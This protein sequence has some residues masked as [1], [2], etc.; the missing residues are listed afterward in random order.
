MAYTITKPLSQIQ[1]NWS[2]HHNDSLTEIKSLYGQRAVAEKL[3][4]FTEFTLERVKAAAQAYYTVLY[5]QY[6]KGVVSGFKD[7]LYMC[8][9]SFSL[10]PTECSIQFDSFIRFLRDL[11]LDVKLI[12]NSRF[13][14]S[15]SANAK[16]VARER[17]QPERMQ[18]ELNAT[19]DLWDAY[20][21]DHPNHAM[22]IYYDDLYDAQRNVTIAQALLSFLGEDPKTPV[23]FA[24]MPAERGRSVG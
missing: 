10:N 23:S 1:F 6:G 3:P 24:R 4:W 8:G 13:E 18:A 11:C 16:L 2:Q 17:R 21:L 7:S 15:L 9:R 20:V 22:R 12:F 5:G 19:L 14:S